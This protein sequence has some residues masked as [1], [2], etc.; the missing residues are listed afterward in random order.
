[1]LRPQTWYLL[2]A[3]LC[4]L[5]CLIAG[6]GTTLQVVLLIVAAVAS[7]AIVPLYKNR[8][9]Q[10][11]LTLLP[12]VL[13]LAWYVLLALYA[14]PEIMHWNYVLPAVAILALVMARKGIVHDEKVVR[15]LDRIR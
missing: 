12:M 13:L 2:L 10:A 6:G 15:S 11:A 5:V 14:V 3:A 7:A 1:M 4:A 8:R 9:L